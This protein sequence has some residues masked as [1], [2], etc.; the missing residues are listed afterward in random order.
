MYTGRSLLFVGMGQ[1]NR[2]LNIHEPSQRLDGGASRNRTRWAPIVAGAIAA[3]YLLG[4]V[5]AWSDA[6][7]PR[8]TRASAETSWPGGDTSL[9]G[10][11]TRPSRRG[12]RWSR[13]GSNVSPGPTLLGEEPDD[14]PLRACGPVPRLGVAA[15]AG[16]AAAGGGGCDASAAP[17][18]TTITAISSSPTRRSRCCSGRLPIPACECG[19]ARGPGRPPLRPC[20]S[21]RLSF[22]CRP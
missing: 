3:V 1:W 16:P 19:T 12:C 2:P 13:P 11:G 8:C 9:T 7:Q 15:A 14:V 18:C 4:V 10:G 17:P 21:S 22:A 5:D 20:A 6:G